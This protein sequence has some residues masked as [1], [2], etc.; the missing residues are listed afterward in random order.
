[1]TRLELDEVCREAVASERA[2][3]KALAGLPVRGKVGERIR[4]VLARRGE[5]P[6]NETKREAK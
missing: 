4:E 2:V 6:C 5:P 1:M 3:L